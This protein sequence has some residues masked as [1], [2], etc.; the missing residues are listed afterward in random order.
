LPIVYALRRVVVFA[1]CQRRQ[2]SLGYD[3]VSRMQRF[4]PL[5]VIFLSDPM[6]FG[7]VAPARAWELGQ[8]GAAQG[9]AVAHILALAS[10]TLLNLMSDARGTM[11]FS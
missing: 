10:P 4:L 1:G 11:R 3:R 5:P 2:D 6:T 9:S 7:T 8:A